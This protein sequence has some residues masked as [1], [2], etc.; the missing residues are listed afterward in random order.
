MPGHFFATLLICLALSVGPAAARDL[1][2]EMEVLHIAGGISPAQIDALLADERLSI[3]I[4][5]EPTRLI[6]GV[7]AR[8][9]R[10]MPIGS[11]LFAISRDLSLE[12]AQIEREGRLL[13]FRVPG[14]HPEHP[15]HYRVYSV[16]LRA[17]ARSRS[18]PDLRFDLVRR[19]EAG[20][21]EK[22]QLKWIETSDLGLRVRHRWSDARGATVRH[23][24]RCDRDIE[25]LANGQYRFRARHRLEGEFR[26]LASTAQSD[27]PSR[28]KP[29]Q[30][31]LQLREPYPEPL[32]G[33]QVSRSHLVQMEIDGLT[34]ERFAVLAKQ[35]GE[36]RC[37][38]VNSYDAL[39]AGGKVVEV[40]R[41]YNAL[42]CA[43]G[44][45]RGRSVEARWLEDGTLAHYVGG[46]RDWDGFL[47]ARADQCTTDAAPPAAEV[48]ALE[49][50]FQRIREAFLRP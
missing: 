18:Q 38:H 21:H 12:S 47:A 34:V 4:N 46:G 43:A 25:P 44:E 2:V 48:Q 26:G 39:Y 22:I 8:R 24:P 13:R 15:E 42:F 35:S 49:S 28:P 31:S 16:T 41:L 17:P 50:E 6:E 32:A 36:G 7:T 29:G 20:D 1:H 45:E 10:I 37:E 9:E 11:K 27:P 40:R 33:W 19:P 30:R 14:N 23:A 5:Y 3:E